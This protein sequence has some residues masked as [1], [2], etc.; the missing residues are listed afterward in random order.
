MA[1]KSKNSSNQK[2]SAQKT[3]V[4]SKKNTTKID[5]IKIDEVEIDEVEIDEVEIDEVEI[6]EVEIDEV[7]IDETGLD[8]VDVKIDTYDI[9]GVK[10]TD[11]K[12]DE[13]SVR[14]IDVDG[15]EGIEVDEVYEELIYVEDSLSDEE[16]EQ[17]LATHPVPPEMKKYLLIGAV[18]AG[19]NGELYETLALTGDVE[20]YLEELY[21]DWNLC[22][23]DDAVEMMDW[24][25]AEGHAAAYRE[26][27][28]SYK[29][30]NVCNLTEED[31]VNYELTVDSLIDILGLPQD[32][33]NGCESLGGWD[34]DRIGYLARVFAHVGLISET[35]AWY[36]LQKGA[37]LAESQFKSWEEY[38]ISLLIGRGFAE[39]FDEEPFIVVY[40]LLTKNRQL[41]DKYPISDL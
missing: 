27:F 40:D 7:E 14:E 12:M 9:D 6:D 11:I 36:Y 23:K 18:L 2:P 17:F 21:E 31:I 4:K 34:I 20:D 35:D 41:I 13:I 5:E 22:T 3:D 1:S 29:I 10:V 26:D 37:A 30:G 33:V 39:G 8:E 24:L 32:L 15:I 19:A 16:I 38:F 25:I 28:L